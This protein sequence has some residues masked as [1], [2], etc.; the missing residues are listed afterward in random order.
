MEN[1]S[2]LQLELFQTENAGRAIPQANNPYFTF[3]KN[4]EKTVLLAIGI[5]ATGIVSFSLGVEKGKQVST[6]KKDYRMDVAAGVKTK[7]LTAAPAQVYRQAP[8]IYE[9]QGSKDKE[10]EPQEKQRYYIQLASYKGRANAQK[11]MDVLK[12]RGLSAVILPKGNYIVLYL[13]NLPSKTKAEAMLSELKK[14]YKDC[15]IRRRL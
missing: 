8:V 14:R 1:G 10:D 3:L 2:D 11:E 4:Y 9:E 6:L 12:R 7:G 13:N 15:Q 5:V